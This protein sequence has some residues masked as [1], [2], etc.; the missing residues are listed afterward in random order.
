MTQ[1]NRFRLIV[2]EGNSHEAAAVHESELDDWA[3]YEHLKLPGFD[4]SYSLSLSGLW[5]QFFETDHAPIE[6]TLTG[7][8]T[9]IKFGGTMQLKQLFRVTLELATRQQ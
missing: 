4:G 8:E 9:I 3:R 1:S 7:Y 6:Q 5:G 2:F